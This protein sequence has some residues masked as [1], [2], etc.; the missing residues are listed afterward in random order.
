MRRTWKAAVIGLVVATVGLTAAALPSVSALEDSFGLRWLFFIRGPLEPPA[1]AVIAS[2]D[3]SS[4]VRMGV[5]Q[6]VRDWPR[7]VHGVLCASLLM[8]FGILPGGSAYLIR[9]GSRLNGNRAAYRSR[10]LLDAD[11]AARGARLGPIFC[12]PGFEQL[13]LLEASES[14]ALASKQPCHQI[15]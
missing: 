9:M 15:Q 2:T 8:L 4:A 13:A 12:D 3:E 6:R 11:Q 14:L 5:P 1:A 7:S 10:F